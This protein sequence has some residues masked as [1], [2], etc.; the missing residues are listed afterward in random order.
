MTEISDLNLLQTNDLHFRKKNM[1]GMQ[2]AYNK[3]VKSMS[4]FD[5]SPLTCSKNVL[6]YLSVRQRVV[7]SNVANVNTPGYKTREVSFSSV[8]DSKNDALR[9]KL[10]RTHE[11]HFP[12]GEHDS[13]G[14]ETYYSYAPQNPKDG[15]N[16]VDLDKEMLK[17]AEIQANYKMFSEI[18]TRKYRSIKNTIS[19]TV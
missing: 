9:I 15:V 10:T 1:C 12:K 6:D 16:D 11:R 18:L 17:E 4:M 2:V 3:S 5:R 7:A 13:A 14:I 19:G 8:L